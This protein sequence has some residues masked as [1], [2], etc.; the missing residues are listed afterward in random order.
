MLGAL[1][2]GARAGGGRRRGV[3]G[4]RARRRA[5]GAGRGRGPPAPPT[6]S[7]AGAR[8]SSPAA[9]AGA[10][11]AGRR[12]GRGLLPP[13]VPPPGEG[14]SARASAASH[15]IPITVAAEQGVGGLALYLALRRRRAARP[16]ARRAGVVARAAVAAA[17]VALV[18]HTLLY[19]AFLEDPLAWALLAVGTALDAGGHVAPPR[20]RRPPRR[21][22]SATRGERLALAALIARGGRGLGARPD[23]SRL[24]RLPPPDLGPR[25]CCTASRPA[26]RRSPRRPST[27]CTSR[28]RR[29]C[30]SPAEDADRLLVLVTLLSLAALTAGAYALGRE[31]FG[32]APALLGALL[33]RLELRLPAVRGARVRRRPV[34]RARRV[35]GGARGARGRGGAWRRWR[36]WR[37][38]GCCGPRRGCWRGVYWLWCLPGRGTRERAGLLAL[39]AVAPLGWALVDLAVTGDPLYSLHATNELADELGRER[40]IGAVPGSFVTFLADGRTAAGRARGRHRD[41]A[42][43]APLRRRA[44]GRAARAARGG[45]ADVR[46]DR[47]R[48]AVDHPALPDRAG[49]R[50]VRAR[51]LRGAGLHDARAGGARTRWRGAAV[52]ALVVGAAFLVVKASS[53]EKLRTELRFIQSTHAQ[54]RTLLGHPAVRSGMRCGALTFPTYRLVPDARWMLHAG[55]RRVRSRAQDP[56]AR[57]G[58]RLP[59]RRRDV[60]APLRPCRR[61]QPCDEHA[62][63]RRADAALGAVRG[64]RGA[65]LLTAG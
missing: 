18:V 12:L 52:G 43:R 64:L 57:R 59:H 41:R 15:T 28:W 31:L 30:R 45:R 33:R 11:P 16:A 42:R 47:H 17:F 55:P 44:D 25:R 24:R 13:R 22:V 34:P 63:R 5:R 50:A 10:R 6:T 39:V 62:S 56:R 61:G 3:R 60:R 9:R 27:R 51:G 48:G 29:C 26:S 53:F 35:G 7:R 14:S 38:R 8:R 23:V 65:P 21:V 4:R 32:R 49:R 36:C 19:A 58:R 2:W 40:G 46:R 20:A 54:L 37:S 1:R